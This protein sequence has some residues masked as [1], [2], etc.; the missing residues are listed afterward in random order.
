M[1]DVI[2]SFKNTM[3]P[4]WDAIAA[5]HFDLIICVIGMMGYLILVYSRKCYTAQEFHKKVDVTFEDSQASEATET[6]KDIDANSLGDILDSMQ[7]CEDVDVV[8]ADMDKFLESNPGHPFTIFEVQAILKFCS[9]PLADKTLADRLLRCMQSVEE[10]CVLNAFICYYLANK[11]SEKAC[12]IFELNYA[13]FF[14]FEL[15][16]STEWQLVMA[17]L[18]CGRTSLA[19]HLIQTS[20]PDAAKQ[21]VTIQQWWKRTSGQMGEAR[22]AQMGSVLT[23][24]SNMFNERYPFEEDEEHS[25][26]ESTAFFGDDSE[27]GQTDDSDWEPMS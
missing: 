10:S 7:S 8:T 1:Q 4:V 14:D 20:Q 11:M 13:T 12:N 6:K 21:I 16:E 5:S 2:V 3:H 9:Q 25:D 23:R 22:V 18:K 17:A 27:H 26:G 15:D 24:L 19:D